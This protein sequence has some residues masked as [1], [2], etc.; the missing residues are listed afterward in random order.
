MP[1]Y[2]AFTVADPGD[3][4]PRAELTY[5]YR[6][7]RSCSKVMFSQVSVILFTGGRGCVWQKTLSR[8]PLARHPL[9]RHPPAD[10]PLGKHP[11]GRRPRADTPPTGQTPP[12]QTP[13]AECMLAYDGHCSGRYAS[14]WNAFL[15]GIFLPK[16][17]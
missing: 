10:T 15:F 13:P 11:L 5:F 16:A 6:P 14:Y 4:N 9:G 7:Q 1:H 8:H 3:T 17:A 12:M 2:P